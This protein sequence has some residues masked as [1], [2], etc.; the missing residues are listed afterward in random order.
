MSARR[1]L[2]IDNDDDFHRLLH[3][4]LSPYGF[5]IHQIAATADALAH[6]ARV[7]PALVFISVEEPDK[8]GYSLCNKA[9][10]SVAREMPVVLTTAS[11]PPSG[12]QSHRRLKVHADEYL[13]KRT[14]STEELIDKVDALIGLGGGQSELIDFPLEVEE[15]D[16]EEAEEVLVEDIEMTGLGDEPGDEEE[17]TRIA[18]PDI[19][20]EALGE[21]SVAALL[22]MSGDPDLDDLAAID[23]EL[24]ASLSARMTAPSDDVARGSDLD[25]GDASGMPLDDMGD[26]DSSPL[27]TREVE[28]V[29]T[30]SAAAAEPPLFDEIETSSLPDPSFSQM[31][32]EVVESTFEFDPATGAAPDARGPAVGRAPDG[33]QAARQAALEQESQRLRAELDAARQE[34][35][36]LRA[37]LDTR[38]RESERLRTEIDPG[39]PD[40]QR[41]LE[42]E[43]QSLRAE[44]DSKKHDSDRLRAE[45]DAKKQESDRLRAE[46][47]ANKQD[48]DRL[49]AELDANKQEAERLRA[50]LDPG[51]PDRQ[52]ALEQENQRLRAEI[53]AKKQES[54]RLRTELDQARAGAAGGAG[55]SR[56]RELLSLREVIN[57]KDHEILELRDEVGLKDREILDRKEQIRKLEHNKTALE[58]KNLELEQRILEHSETIE[59]LDRD[60]RGLSADKDGLAARIAELEA[61]LQAQKEAGAAEL[62][63]LQRVR[64][65]AEQALRAE[66]VQAVAALEKQHASALAERDAQREQALRELRAEL[67]RQQQEALDARDR[68]HGQSL[69]ER[70]AAHAD[71]LKQAEARHQAALA[72]AE[73][74]HRG[75]REEVEARHRAALAE[76]EA[77]HRAAQAQA[78]A[79]H[80]QAQ[81]DAAVK[82]AE[83]RDALRQSHADELTGMRARHTEE[84]ARQAE[85][86]GRAQ[87]AAVSAATRALEEQHAKALAQRERA[88]QEALEQARRQAK[89]EREDAEVEHERALAQA[90]QQHAAEKQALASSHAEAV[91]GLEAQ[92]AGL[93]T[94][95]EN[96]QR[97]I[98]RLDHELR[99]D[100]RTLAEKDQA[101]SER[102]ARLAA[103]KGELEEIESQNADYQE[104]VLKAYRRIKADEAAVE[105]AKKALAIALTLLDET[106]GNGRDADASDGSRPGA[107][108]AG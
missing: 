48:G 54:D 59:A 40:R 5:E 83:E 55:F 9:K 22:G 90:A 12:F 105:R 74:Q 32:P 100:R 17:K 51:A 26:L 45:L 69:A 43:N 21:D 93:R 41:A 107:E 87:Q 70:D 85:E 64:D 4:Q 44:I 24:E 18:Q 92:L 63:R 33:A 88:A 30:A 39:A 84:L 25:L 38:K 52:R 76:A 50:E 57:K 56:E 53:D 15:L 66:H 96:A 16:I 71:A 36:R 104:Q 58:S 34:S 94:E 1:L 75:E 7:D 28:A 2:L 23:A 37:E 79:E 72:H 106:A 67:E 31:M 13:D 102:D 95:I 68:A 77:R 62:E 47:D 6:V 98:G 86:H 3:E 42:Q 35:D 108:E 10:K 49:R 8:L 19:I 89:A 78:E 80:R 82:A 81:A 46:I 11:V 29:V 61:A 97:T 73:S 65:S 99:T 101:I 20:S 91:Q 60:K 103:L 14:M 27:S